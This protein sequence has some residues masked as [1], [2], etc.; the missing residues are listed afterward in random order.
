MRWFCFVA[1]LSLI[2]ATNSAN[3]EFF[4][5]HGYAKDAGDSGCS[6]CGNIALSGCC[7]ECSYCDQLWNNYC[8]QASHVCHLGLGG[9]FGMG[10]SAHNDCCE[11]QLSLRHCC[12]GCCGCGLNIIGKM[13]EW[14]S[15]LQCHIKSRLP[16]ITGFH[17]VCCDT[18]CE[19][20]GC[21]ECSSGGCSVSLEPTTGPNLADPP[22]PKGDYHI[23]PPIAPEPAEAR[24]RVPPLLKL[25]NQRRSKPWLTP[26][27]G[28]LLPQSLFKSR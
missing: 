3:A 13:H 14:K 10:H 9:L 21:D 26:R 27:L 11:P 19:S 16:R 28:K 5:I 20:S 2:T 23:S 22:E 1:T 24:Q 17:E 7:D 12:A 18:G 8:D 6:S 25:D 4:K 15:R